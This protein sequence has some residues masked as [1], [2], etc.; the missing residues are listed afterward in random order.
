MRF[1]FRGTEPINF[2][3]EV[4]SRCLGGR[5][6]A[7]QKLLQKLVSWVFVTSIKLLEKWVQ[8]LFVSSHFVEFVFLLLCLS[9]VCP[10]VCL[11]V[12]V[13]LCLF[14]SVF[15]LFL[16]VMLLVCRGASRGCCVCCVWCVCLRGCMCCM[17]LKALMATPALALRFKGKRIP[18]FLWEIIQTVRPNGLAIFVL[19][20]KF[21]ITV[22]IQTVKARPCARQ[23]DWFS[24]T[25]QIQTAKR[26]ACRR[27]RWRETVDVGM[28]GWFR[29]WQPGGWQ[30]RVVG[31]VRGVGGSGITDDVFWRTIIIVR[32]ISGLTRLNKSMESLKIDTRTEIKQEIRKVK[33]IR[34]HLVEV[35]EMNRRMKAEMEP[36]FR[37][38]ENEDY[39]A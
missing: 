22:R 17:R 34:K 4:E 16:C 37:N 29:V 8:T 21:S 20:A 31:G 1:F 28:L 18:E 6:L 24:W 30:L 32:L 2:W 5:A 25:A 9:V 11:S 26:T 10:S 15:V 39:D 35:T 27:W 33:E 38:E 3:A 14:L 23:L 12:C 19:L 36:G 7:S 13:S